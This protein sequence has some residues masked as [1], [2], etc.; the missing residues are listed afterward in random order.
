MENLNAEQIIKDLEWLEIAATNM[1]AC[2]I[3]AAKLKHIVAFIRQLTEEV[4]DLK[5]IAEGYRKQFE[6]CA[7]DRARLTEDNERLQKATAELS[8][9]NVAL[10]KEK[11]ALECIVATTRNQGRA[12]T[13]KEMAERLKQMILSNFPNLQGLPPFIDQTEKEMLEEVEK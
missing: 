11:T 8:T 7:E 12:A 13:V 1:G 4:A 2:T 6:D 3:S 9:E 10:I 5:A